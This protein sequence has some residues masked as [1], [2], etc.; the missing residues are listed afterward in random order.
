LPALDNF[1]LETCEV[2]DC[3]SQ[4]ANFVV[5]KRK[6]LEFNIPNTKVSRSDSVELGNKILS[7]TMSERKGLAL[8]KATLWYQQKKVGEGKTLRIYLKSRPKL[9]A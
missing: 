3:V 6:E 2:L 5:G 7:I 8:N 4:L 9:N 1:E